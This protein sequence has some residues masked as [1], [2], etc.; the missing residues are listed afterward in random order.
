MFLKVGIAKSKKK[1]TVSFLG[2]KIFFRNPVKPEVCTILVL[3][4]RYDMNKK[5]IL[6]LQLSLF[7]ESS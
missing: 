7:R 2:I 5:D 6:S 3:A 4:I 1:S